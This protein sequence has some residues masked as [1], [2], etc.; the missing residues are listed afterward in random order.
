MQ[1]YQE[2][3]DFT[4][5]YID[6]EH[7]F[8]TYKTLINGMNYVYGMDVQGDIAEFGTMTGR[9]AVA[10]SVSLRRLEEKYGPIDPRGGKKIWFFD[11]FEGLQT[12]KSDVD[13]NCP[14]VKTEIWGPGTCKGLNVDQ[15][16]N[17]ISQILEP[18]QFSV[19]EGWYENTMANLDDQKFSLVHIDCDLYESTIQVLEE[20]FSK[21]RVTCGCIIFFDDW[22]CNYASNS[23]GERKA[24]LDTVSKY[25]VVYSDCGDYGVASKKFIIHSYGKIVNEVDDRDMVGVC[26]PQPYA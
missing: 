4:T 16:N 12:S 10:L 24:W 8:E 15:F 21:N 19:I 5:S 11:S 7:Q 9:T 1:T 6:T 3:A 14:H 17:L 26:G 25:N 18:K 22:N 20:L 23:F 13:I 2:I